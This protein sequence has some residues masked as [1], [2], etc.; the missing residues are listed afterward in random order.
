MTD[1]RRD[2]TVIV[3]TAA[4]LGFWFAVLFATAL[5]CLACFALVDWIGTR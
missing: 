3:E 1:G 4:V 2:V 5:A